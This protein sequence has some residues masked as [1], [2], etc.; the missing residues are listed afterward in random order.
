MI[1]LEQIDKVS[2]KCHRRRIVIECEAF[3]ADPENMKRFEE[4]KENRDARRR[5]EEMAGRADTVRRKEI[6][7]SLSPQGS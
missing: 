6:L 5:E 2:L 3:F 7:Q 1:P 4:W